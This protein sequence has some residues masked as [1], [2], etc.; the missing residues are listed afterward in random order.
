MLN[1]AQYSNFFTMKGS[2][3]TG[4]LAIADN[5]LSSKAI[6]EI[7]SC[8]HKLD[9]GANFTEMGVGSLQV[10]L[11]IANFVLK[12]PS[13]NLSVKEVGLSV[14]QSILMENSSV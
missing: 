4:F 14:A 5:K 2:L 8:L 13:V 7:T 1:E 6:T 3:L 9:Q 11:T 10:C 12:D